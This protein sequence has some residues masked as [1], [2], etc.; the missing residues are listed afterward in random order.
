[1]IG[2]VLVAVALV[3]YVR[4]EGNRIIRAALDEADAQREWERITLA[5]RV[6]LY[7]AGIGR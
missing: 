7:D 3:V 5:D 2:A 4:L 6:T 1:M